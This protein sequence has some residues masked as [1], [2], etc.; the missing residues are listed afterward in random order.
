MHADFE[1]DDPR[2]RQR[3]GV[4]LAELPW[5]WPSRTNAKHAGARAAT[6][7]DDAAPLL[8]GETLLLT[9]CASEGSLWALRLRGAAR[10]EVALDALE[11]WR[12]AADLLPTVLP[13]M[14]QSPRLSDPRTESDS[15]RPL[16]SA[17]PRLRR[18]H[19]PVRVRNASPGTYESV[20]A[21]ESLGLAILLA[22][23]SLM[24]E[25]P[26]PCDLAATATITPN[27]GLGPVG[28]LEAKLRALV[29]LAPR[30][31]RVI[32]AE[33]QRVEADRLV[34]EIAVEE[35]AVPPAV[36]GLAAARDAV[37]LALPEDATEA[38]W[39]CAG[40]DADRRGEHVERLLQLA[41]AERGESSDWRP[42][43]RAASL[44]AQHWSDAAAHE[45]WTLDFV[46]AV[47][48]RHMGRAAERPVSLPTE[49][50]LRAIPQPRRARVLA[51]L[52]QQC[53]DTGDPEPSEVE[54]LALTH[55]VRGPDAFPDHLQLVG[56]VARLVASRGRLDDALAL[57][58]EAAEAW[59]ARPELHLQVSYPLSE[60]FRLA[61]ALK[62][63]SALEAAERLRTRAT[64]ARALAPTSPWVEAPRAR[65]LVAIGRPRAEIL[66]TLDALLAATVP[67]HC[68]Y[69]ARRARRSMAVRDGE[70]DV[71]E[72][73]DADLAQ[74]LKASTHEA[75]HAVSPIDRLRAL[76]L[77]REVETCIALVALDSAGGDERAIAD[78]EARLHDLH[79][80]LCRA[81][82]AEGRAREGG[83][84]EHF[85][86]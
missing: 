46:A 56:A 7:R 85:P 2:A 48:A 15:L 9:E 14:W 53:A 29:R 21:G 33:H 11:V 5:G 4:F 3:L 74:I 79:P 86:Y 57:Q 59:L 27:G 78:A 81:L 13:I 1:A 45:V 51:H 39:R 50:E 73:I 23:A 52:V 64:S 19:A 65:A 47:A 43:E 30:V 18:A 75:R 31:R 26:L 55:L 17:P 32:V 69:V 71:V 10:G 54:R 36:V 41:L 38:A 12:R 16:P 49:D 6:G 58:Q 72:R 70:A 80:E 20:V 62:S 61:A 8:P 22:Q 24:L 77:V 35:G 82:L 60:M 42:I 84:R 37:R 28:G 44:A 76:D 83:L 67:A 34:G 25:M 66:P 40:A 68:G 63:P